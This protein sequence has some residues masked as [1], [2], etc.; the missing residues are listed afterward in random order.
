[1]RILHTGIGDPA[2]PEAP[3]RLA[4]GTGTGLVGSYEVMEK[5]P[6]ELNDDELI[7]RLEDDLKAVK[8]AEILE[9]NAP[10]DLEP[11]PAE[12]HSQEPL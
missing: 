1:M 10:V 7:H 8:P 11:G 5:P 3:G 6:R 2:G 4:R 9:E 12:G